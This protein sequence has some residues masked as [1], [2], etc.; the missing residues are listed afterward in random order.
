MN[1]LGSKEGEEE[2]EEEQVLREV[3]TKYRV[4]DVQVG[5][6]AVVVLGEMVLEKRVKKEYLNNKQIVNNKRFGLV[7]SPH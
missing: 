2:Q 5:L 6:T 3:D 7:C 4:E 1:V